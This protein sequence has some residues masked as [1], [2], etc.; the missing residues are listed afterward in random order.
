MHSSEGGGLKPI[1]ENVFRTSDNNMLELYSKGVLII[2]AEKD[3][4]RF[5]KVEAARLDE[6]NIQ[7]YVGEYYSDEVEAKYQ[8]QVRNGK[9][10]LILKPRIEYELK[11]SYKDG[12]DIPEGVIYFERAKNRVIN[13]KMSVERAWNI[14]FRKIQ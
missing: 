7:E 11:P 4:I 5:T 12:F 3:S 13:F 1:A 6:K 10:L 8:V 2:S 14:E 9:L